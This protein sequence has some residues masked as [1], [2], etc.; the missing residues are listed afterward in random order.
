MSPSL[1]L[2]T[3]WVLR[4]LLGSKRHL[5]RGTSPNP[6]CPTVAV[7]ASAHQSWVTARG[8]W[9]QLCSP[10]CHRIVP[11]RSAVSKKT[12]PLSLFANRNVSKTELPPCLWQKWCASLKQHWLGRVTHL[13]P[14]PQ[15][16]TD[17][18]VSPFDSQKR[19]LLYAKTHVNKLHVSMEIVQN[20]LLTVSCLSY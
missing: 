1:R 18:A 20:S 13:L 15:S 19:S 2:N 16:C 8:N 4:L 17:L 7:C 3:R 11:C 14:G 9:H 12:C 10:A 6:Q 5:G